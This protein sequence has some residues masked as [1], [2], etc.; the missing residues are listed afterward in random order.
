MTVVYPFFGPKDTTNEKGTL[1]PIMTGRVLLGIILYFFGPSG[2]NHTKK[3]PLEYSSIF[4]SNSLNM[5]DTEL[6]FNGLVKLNTERPFFWNK[7]L[8]S[9]VRKTY[10]NGLVFRRTKTS[11]CYPLST[12]KNEKEPL[13]NH[14]GEI[15]GG[16]LFHFANKWQLVVTFEHGTCLH[17]IQ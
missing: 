15:N 11:F 17:F 12:H 5:N 9:Q 7:P 2:P 14:D 4:C 6:T 3:D 10:G 16:E 13:I 1:H 8:L